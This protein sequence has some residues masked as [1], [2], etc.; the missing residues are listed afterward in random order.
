M[1]RK[2]LAPT[3]NQVQALM[4]HR[5]SVDWPRCCSPPASR[6]FYAAWCCSRRQ[7]NW[8]MPLPGG[9]VSQSP[10][11]AK[12]CCWPPSSRCW[13]GSGNRT[14]ASINR[15]KASTDGFRRR[16]ACRL[17]IKRSN[18]VAA[19]K[20]P[21]LTRW[22]ISSTTSSTFTRHCSSVSRSRI[23]TVL[24]CKVWP[25]TVMQYGVPASSCRR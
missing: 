14:A 5:C 17:E 9:G 3:P 2:R 8:P 1:C 22:E 13:Q 12:A 20:R 23:V 18:T 24:S 7:L 19:T 25:S 4:S 16:S 6:R 15:S 11:S 21:Q 10:R